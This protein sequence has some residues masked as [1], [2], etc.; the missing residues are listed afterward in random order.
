MTLIHIQNNKLILQMDQ[1][2][3]GVIC[4]E[5]KRYCCTFAQVLEKE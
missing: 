4:G 1:E 5:K 3:S 2:K